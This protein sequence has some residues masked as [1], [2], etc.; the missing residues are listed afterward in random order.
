MRGE[1]AEDFFLVGMERDRRLVQGQRRIWSGCAAVLDGLGLE[2]SCNPPFNAFEPG[3]R[4]NGFGVVGGTRRGR[5]V[6]GAG[7][8]QGVVD[9]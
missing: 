3:M 2:K 1:C 9:L 6:T 5:G 8:L 4:H 7:G